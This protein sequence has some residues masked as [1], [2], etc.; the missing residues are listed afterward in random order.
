MRMLKEKLQLLEEEADHYK[1]LAMY[2][3]LHP[4][5]SSSAASEKSFASAWF[6]QSREDVL[7][8]MLYIHAAWKLEAMESGDTS[9]EDTFT[10][11]ASKLYNMRIKHDRDHVYEATCVTDHL[12]QKIDSKTVSLNVGAGPEFLQ[13][14]VSGSM[15]YTRRGDPNPLREGD[16]VD[17][18]L[19]FSAATSPAALINTVLDS[20]RGRVE[21][22][23]IVRA[24][25][26]IGMHSSSIEA[27]MRAQIRFYRPKYQS[28][29]D[30]PEQSKGYRFQTARFYRDRAYTLGGKIPLPLFAGVTANV[31]LLGHRSSRSLMHEHFGS[32]TLTG[33]MLRYMRL[34]SVPDP[35]GSW[36]KFCKEQ[37]SS[38]TGLMK[39]LGK[40][41]SNAAQEAA[42]W[43]NKRV[44]DQ[45]EHPIFEQ[46]TDFLEKR[47]NTKTAIGHLTAFF[48]DLQEPFKTMKRNSPLIVPEPLI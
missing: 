30:F 4:N 19:A 25:D 46:M 36:D 35:D 11:I 8:H 3:D 26:G 5:N 47:S 12:T 17:I 27:G 43:D 32:N 16:Y 2:N 31:A 39:E 40:S 15:T 42:Y 23:E 33:P 1:R 10:R 6:A 22:A 14:K 41:S 9:L 29:A 48:A 21:K 13:A 24:F 44:G 34:R 37:E 18:E 38:L 45:P 20:L 7:I 28:A